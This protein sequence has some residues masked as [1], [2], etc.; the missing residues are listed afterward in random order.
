[1]GRGTSAIYQFDLEGKIFAVFTD[2]ILAGEWNKMPKES[3][4]SAVRRKTCVKKKFYFSQSEEFSI[5]NK[6]KQHN[7]LFYKKIKLNEKEDGN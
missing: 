7:P 5:P 4:R 3:I 2:Y 6:K 1:M